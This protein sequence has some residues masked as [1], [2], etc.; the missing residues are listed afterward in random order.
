MSIVNLGSD[1]A[2]SYS[3][4]YHASST[5]DSDNSNAYDH[6]LNRETTFHPRHAHRQRTQ[7]QHKVRR[8]TPS[9]NTNI[10]TAAGSRPNPGHTGRAWATG[11]VRQRGAGTGGDTAP[12]ADQHHRPNERRAESDSPVRVLPG[13][14]ITPGYDNNGN[15]LESSAAAATA[16]PSPTT[17]VGPPRSTGPVLPTLRLSPEPERRH[18]RACTGGGDATVSFYT[19]DM[20]VLQDDVVSSSERLIDHQEHPA[21]KSQMV[22]GLG[23]DNQMVARDGQTSTD[24]GLGVSGSG[25][26]LRIYSAAGRQLERPHANR[27]RR[28]GPGPHRLRPVRQLDVPDQRLCL[29]CQRLRLASTASRAADLTP[30]SAPI[31]LRRPGSTILGRGGG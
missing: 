23:Y 22:W 30:S 8:W 20:Q 10:N 24:A 16:A 1:L 2:A 4:L 26:G 6:R 3:Q 29:R 19:T 7:R 13:I 9:A 17:A 21:Q 18:P 31:P 25:L 12:D 27:Q 11:A 15:T 5:T 28:H 14:G